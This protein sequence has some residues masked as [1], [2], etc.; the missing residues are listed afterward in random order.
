MEKL[1]KTNSSHPRNDEIAVQKEFIERSHL[2]ECQMSCATRP[3]FKTQLNERINSIELTGNSKSNTLYSSM[4]FACK[5][6]RFVV[7]SS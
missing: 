2:S 5:I 4:V 1:V 3:Q 7:F 6:S